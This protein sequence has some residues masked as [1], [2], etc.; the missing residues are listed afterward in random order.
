MEFLDDVHCRRL[1]EDLNLELRESVVFLDVG[2]SL[3]F[4]TDGWESVMNEVKLKR[5]LENW[6]G[7]ISGLVAKLKESIGHPFSSSPT[8]EDDITFFALRIM[9]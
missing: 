4:H 7:P 8:Y 6:T 9:G 3:F 1:G 5:E 2:D